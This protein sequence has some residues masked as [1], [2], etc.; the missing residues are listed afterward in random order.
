VDLR[1]L[2]VEDEPILCQQLASAIEGAGYAVDRADNGEHAD[3]LGQTEAFDAAILD[4]GLPKVD[5]L[6]VLRR[7]REAGIR[8]PVLI[9]TAR[10]SWHEKVQASTAAPTIT[11]RSLSA[12]KKYSPACVR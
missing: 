11:C 12:W 4:L 1:I 6:T 9:L 10:G 2:I 8:I 5:G 7:W 3:Y